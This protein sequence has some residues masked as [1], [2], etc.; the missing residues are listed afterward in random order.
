[1]SDNSA[2]DPAQ[3]DA[4]LRHLG[5][6]RPAETAR[7]TRL[8]GGVSSDIWRVGLADRTVCVKRARPVLAVAAEWHAPVERNE[9]E[10]GWLELAQKICPGAAPRVVGLLPELHLFVMEYLDPAQHPVWK[11]ELAAGRVDATFAAQ[12][13]AVLGKLHAGTASDAAIAERFATDA[14]FHALRIEPYLDATALAHA[15]LAP[16][17]EALAA[18]TAGTRLALVHGDVSPKNLLVGPNG[19]VFLDAE[20]AWYGDPAFDVAF[21]LTHLLLKCL[22]VPTQRDALLRSFDALTA[23]YTERVSWEPVDQLESRVATL[24]PALLL[25]RIDGKS[26]VEY[27]TD[28]T[29]RESVRMVARHLLVHPEPRLSA[30]RDTWKGSFSP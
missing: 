1:M 15:E 8:T 25:A 24:L 10:V 20:C 26:P 30:V 27:L 9:S 4:A 22:W 12:V 21:C 18:R 14:L 6:L 7:W 23:A 3:L 28:E 13:G 5:L 19:P 29:E 17:I 2:A 11:Q 16:Q